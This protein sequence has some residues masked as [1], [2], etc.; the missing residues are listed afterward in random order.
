MQKI[1]IEA[2]WKW[3]LTLRSCWVSI[4]GCCVCIH[5]QVSS[6]ILHWASCNLRR[7]PHQS[8]AYS[9]YL[10]RASS[11]PLQLDANRSNR[12]P[13]II[14]LVSNLALLIWLYSARTEIQSESNRPYLWNILLVL[15][16]S[17]MEAFWLRRASCLSEI[18]KIQMRGTFRN[19]S[20][21]SPLLTNKL[22][23]KH[24]SAVH[25][26]CFLTSM[27]NAHTVS[28]SFIPLVVDFRCLCFCDAFFLSSPRKW[29]MQATATWKSWCFWSVFLRL[30]TA[31]AV[32]SG[33]EK[34]VRAK[35]RDRTHPAAPFQMAK[36]SAK[37]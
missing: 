34:V 31:A 21:L 29:N 18:D 1:W 36:N 8:L 11:N 14:A 19:W 3:A 5:C 25:E 13:F 20:C 10:P 27:R 30:A 7:P 23:Y 35:R 33:F 37:C 16:D 22:F 17:K 32:H 15:V 4:C 28:T 2:N 12:H 24:V 26:Q 6:Q 9:P